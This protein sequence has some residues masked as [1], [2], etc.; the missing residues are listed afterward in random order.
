VG[1]D[2]GFLLCY[3]FTHI[4]EIINAIVYVEV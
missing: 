4:Y 3:A 2:T 1:K